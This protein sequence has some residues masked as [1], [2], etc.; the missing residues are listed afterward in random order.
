MFVMWQVCPPK[1]QMTP[2]QIFAR[3][4][5]GPDLGAAVDR[6]RAGDALHRPLA[7][8]ALKLRE[9]LTAKEGEV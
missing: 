9:D 7:E 5:G 6:A 2:M 3:L 1:S 4:K 8:E